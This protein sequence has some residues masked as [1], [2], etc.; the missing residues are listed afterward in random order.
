MRISRR[1]VVQGAG[2]VGLGLL[3]GCGRLPWQGQ[4]LVRTPRVGVLSSILSFAATPE[5]EAFREGLREYGYVEGHNITIEFRSAEGQ[6]EQ[7]PDLAAELVRLPVEIIVAAGDPA[8]RAA[9]QMTDTIPIVGVVGLRNPVESGLVASLARPGGNITGTSDLRLQ[10]TAKRLEL[11]KTTMPRMTR[12]HV[13]GPPGHPEFQEAEVAAARLSV[14]LQPL[15]VRNLEDYE[16]AFEAA[17]RERAE[18]L[19]VLV[20]PVTIAYPTLIAELALRKRLPATFDRRA[21]VDAGGLMSYGP[22]TTGLWRRSA[23]YVDRIL[24]GTSPADLPIEQPM[25]FDFV[26]NLQTA[27]ALGLTIPPHVLLQATEII[28]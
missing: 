14:Q 11:L 24:Q 1:Q 21:F 6:V 17:T 18:A 5:A 25:R 27:Q 13:L 22:S 20:S 10:L 26:I 15:E 8:V 19:L 7:L 23:Y 4:H 9:K 28:Q 16:G 12:V 3:A 2:A